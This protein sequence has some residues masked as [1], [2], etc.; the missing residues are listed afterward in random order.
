MVNASCGAGEMYRAPGLRVLATCCKQSG[1]GVV[2][3]K[4]QADELNPVICCLLSW[5]CICQVIQHA[6]L[7]CLNMLWWIGML[8][9]CWSPQVPMWGSPAR[10]CQAQWA[11]GRSHSHL[12]ASAC[13]NKQKLDKY[14]SQ[15]AVLFAEMPVGVGIA[16]AGCVPRVGGSVSMQGL[17]TRS[18][19]VFICTKHLHKNGTMQ[20]AGCVRV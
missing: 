4:L 18:L 19:G 12:H 16:P 17:W 14:R 15:H 2:C 20:T 1:G 3:Q 11:H 10:T 8:W 9:C 5:C 7:R 6:L 13:D